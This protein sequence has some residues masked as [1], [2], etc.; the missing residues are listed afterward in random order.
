V[1][2]LTAAGWIDRAIIQKAAKYDRATKRSMLLAIDVAHFGVLATSH[3]IET[4]LKAHGDPS[5]YGF[6]A[7]W[8]VGPTVDLS[9]PLGD[10]RW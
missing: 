10:S 7:I 1:K 3:C 2:L 6:A 9:A 8:L 4:F 5:R